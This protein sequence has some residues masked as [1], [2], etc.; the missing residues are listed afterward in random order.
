MA[1]LFPTYVARAI[2]Y[3]HDG[4]KQFVAT[5]QRGAIQHI[6]SQALQYLTIAFVVLSALT[7]LAV[8]APIPADWVLLTFAV[9]PIW[10]MTGWLLT[11]WP[12]NDRL[13]DFR[14][15]SFFPA[16]ATC[17]PP[18]LFGYST[19]GA[20]Y[21]VAVGSLLV[22]GYWLAAFRLRRPKHLA[23]LG[24]AT[25]LALAL[26]TA[27]TIQHDNPFVE[28]VRVT[29]FGVLLT[30][31]M[32]VAESSRVTARVLQNRE[33]RRQTEHTAGERAYYLAGT[34]VA[35]AL[36]LPFFIATGLHPNVTPLYFWLILTIITAQYFAW[37][38]DTGSTKW[39]IWPAIGFITGL[40]MPLAVTTINA[41]RIV[42]QL[43]ISR[44]PTSIWEICGSIALPWALC[45]FVEKS[46]KP[47]AQLRQRGLRL[48]F[49]DARHCIALTAIASGMLAGLLM[50]AATSLNIAPTGPLSDAVASHYATPAIVYFLIQLICSVILVLMAWMDG[51]VAQTTQSATISEENSTARDAT[52]RDGLKVLWALFGSTRI[53]SSIIAGVLSAVVVLHVA[54]VSAW[55]RAIAAGVCMTLLPMFGFVVN[56][57]FDRNKD[58]LAGVDRPIAKGRVN[59]SSARAFAVVLGL[60][61]VVVAQLTGE[62]PIVLGGITALMLYTPV[63]QAVPLIKGVYTALLCMI[64]VWYGSALT[65]VAPNMAV[66]V[67]MIIFIVGRELMLDALDIHGDTLWGLRTIAVRMGGRAALRLSRLVMVLGMLIA[68]VSV[69]SG[70]ARLM[71]L[72]A[73]AAT[74]VILAVPANNRLVAAQLRLP[75]L[76]GALAVAVAMV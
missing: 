47:L 52:P 66:L 20:W 60:A 34:N 25:F 37:F 49:I 5:G 48:T 68:L 50:V 71:A 56:D 3:E 70:Y 58:R 62:V 43:P 15:R 13:Y 45:G 24:G 28:C 69:P 53:G 44:I 22:I 30:L 31:A 65:G 14:F 41:T 46:I 40:T 36:C 42:A 33:Y 8:G 39:A 9:L 64:P 29:T 4:L 17:L 2:L 74:V 21:C 35:T 19:H 7:Y 61:A 12:D 38:V 54:G 55:R 18:F 57:L 73:T 26:I 27:L 67:A 16:F 59:P 76:L 1:L 10:I 72:L 23:L 6:R 75:M 51:Q 32:G 11:T 63:A